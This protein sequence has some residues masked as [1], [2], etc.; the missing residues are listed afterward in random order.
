MAFRETERWR[1]TTSRRRKWWREVL[2]R[3]KPMEDKW[4]VNSLFDAW[5]AGKN[6]GRI[7]VEEK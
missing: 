7:D 4:V 1:K 3:Q 6:V 5:A 2:W